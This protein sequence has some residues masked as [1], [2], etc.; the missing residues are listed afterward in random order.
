L[1]TDHLGTPIAGDVLGVITAQFLGADT[2]CTPVTSNSMVA[3]M[4][5]FDLHQTQVG[6]PFVIAAMQAVFAKNPAARVAGFEANGGF[7]MGFDGAVPA[8]MTRDAMLPILAVL[9]VGLT[10]EA[11]LRT[12]VDAL[13]SRFTAADRVADTDAN[14]V[15]KLMDK[16]QDHA[17]AEAF[18]GKK[19]T[20]INRLDGMRM[21]D[22]LGRIVHLRP[23]GNAPEFR[24]YTEAETVRIAQQMLANMM[25]K[26]AAELR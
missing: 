3:Q 11:S 8:A 5:Q 19:I 6:S 25:M 21:T 22:D 24:C 9:T 23:S 20:A 12:C 1:V 15:L 26:L 13:P 14:K 7:L 4:P 2:I 17:A 18:L 10:G 16:L